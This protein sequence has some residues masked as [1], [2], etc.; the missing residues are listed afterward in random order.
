MGCGKEEAENFYESEL[1]DEIYLRFITLGAGEPI[2]EWCE[3]S[4]EWATAAIETRRKY[5]KGRNYGN[6]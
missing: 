3:N 4:C 6:S 2:T 1:W 5:L